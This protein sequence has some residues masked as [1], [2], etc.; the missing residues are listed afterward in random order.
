[1]DTNFCN[2]LNI[3]DR[4]FKTYQPEQASEPVVYGITRTMRPNSFLDAYFGEFG[5]LFKDVYRAPGFKNKFLYFFM[6]PG[7]SHTGAH[8]T[9]TKI[10]T[11]FLN[12]SFVA[13]Q[14]PSATVA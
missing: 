12:Q 4:V 10:R 3:W 11:E 5:A 6:P 7:W 9:A 13:K 2:L 1:M 8:K 14:E